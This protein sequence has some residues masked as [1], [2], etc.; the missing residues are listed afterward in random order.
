MEYSTEFLTKDPFDYFLPSNEKHYSVLKVITY[1]I[2][3]M[4][5]T[6][7]KLRC[8]SMPEMIE[9]IIK[10]ELSLKNLDIDIINNLIT[11]DEYL[12]KYNVLNGI[13]LNEIGSQIFNEK[14]L[15]AQRKHLSYVKEFIE[16][17]NHFLS[18]K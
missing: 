16:N 18:K 15:N 4:R 9:F 17:K 11:Y 8:E 13:L 3:N 7:K 6:A 10:F 5:V 1:D 12:K 14:V 2:H